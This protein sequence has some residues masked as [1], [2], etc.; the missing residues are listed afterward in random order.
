MNS[1]PISKHL[2]A[3]LG[4]LIVSA[5]ALAAVVFTSEP[6]TSAAVGRAYSYRMTAIIKNDKNDKN[7]NDRHLKFIAR[8]LPPWLA[9]DGNDTIFGTPRQEDIGVHRVRL[10]AKLKGDRVDQEFLINVEPM[11]SRPPPEG[12]DLAAL[13]SVIPR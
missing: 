7:D 11:P 4:A 5:P 1:P 9:F 8:A 13:I 3:V 12:A 6:L 10:R 2:I